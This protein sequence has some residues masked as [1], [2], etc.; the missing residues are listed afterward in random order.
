M[1]AGNKLMLNKP[2]VMFNKYCVIRKKYKSALFGSIVK[3]NIF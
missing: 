3:I 2:S 1:Q